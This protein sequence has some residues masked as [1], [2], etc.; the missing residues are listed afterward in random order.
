MSFRSCSRQLCP[1]QGL[2]T[3]TTFNGR[4]HVC[5]TLIRI[6]ESLFSRWEANINVLK[7]SW[8]A[9]NLQQKSYSF[10]DCSKMVIRSDI[11]LCSV[12][13]PWVVCGSG[14][15]CPAGSVCGEG[16]FPQLC[17]TCSTTSKNPSFETQ[18][19]VTNST[20]AMLS[21][22][23]WT[24]DE[25]YNHTGVDLILTMYVKSLILISTLT[26]D[27][28]KLHLNFQPRIWRFQYLIL[29]LWWCFQGKLELVTFW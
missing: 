16:M 17:V 3:A 15:I 18:H 20:A 19:V 12:V 13:T 24:R 23:F 22:K 6:H 4:S 10:S 28:E 5:F 9:G 29:H 26:V 11:Y 8:M 21:G 1:S 14:Q 7:V 25:F 27:D 2:G